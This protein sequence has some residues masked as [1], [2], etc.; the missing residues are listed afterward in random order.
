M[1]K[2]VKK[3]LEER[4]ERISNL[5]FAEVVS[6]AGEFVGRFPGGEKL[7]PEEMDVYVKLGSRR[8]REK[9]QEIGVI[10]SEKEVSKCQKN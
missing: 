7:G 9:L 3:F 4:A 1:K 5:L 8:L 10:V 6:T 2:A